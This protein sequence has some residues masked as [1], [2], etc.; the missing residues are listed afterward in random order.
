MRATLSLPPIALD[1][2]PE[3]TK[4]YILG[5]CNGSDLTPQEAV[6]RVLNGA[7]RPFLPVQGA[8][9][10]QPEATANAAMVA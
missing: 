8:D 9:A 5:M 4:D 10:A 2:L 7:A 6:R 1:S 3:A